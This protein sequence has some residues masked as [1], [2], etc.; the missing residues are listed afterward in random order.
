MQP[1]LRMFSEVLVL[2][3]K[4]AY[5]DPVSLISPQ[6]SYFFFFKKSSMFVDVGSLSQ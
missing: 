6:V 3:G 2:Y 1:W 5:A 4:E